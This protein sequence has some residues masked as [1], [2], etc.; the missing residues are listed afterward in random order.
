MLSYSVGASI[1]RIRGGALR[2][3]HPNS[4]SP[5]SY[6][7]DLHLSDLPI[8][9]SRHPRFWQRADQVLLYSYC[10]WEVAGYEFSTVVAPRRCGNHALV[11]WAPGVSA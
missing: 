5:D 10:D 6:D 11:T 9:G 8:K 7:R 2:Q 1:L 4:P 3:R